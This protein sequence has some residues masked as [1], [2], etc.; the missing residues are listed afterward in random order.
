V[1][2]H[3]H[4]TTVR[5]YP[6]SVA[7]EG[8]PMIGAGADEP[9]AEERRAAER[10][11]LLG[12]FGVRAECLALGVDRLD[13]T[14]GIIERL[15]GLEEFFDEHPGYRER[16]TMVQ[17]AAPSRTRIPSY[18]ELRARVDETV[19]RI[20]WR[21]QTAH[22]KPIVL[23][24]RQ[25]SHNEVKRWYQTAD[26]CL[27]T[28]LH[29]GMNLVAKEYV[30]ARDDEDGVLVLSKFTGAAVELLDALIVNPYDIRGVSA[31]MY[32]GL[33][34]SRAERRQ[35]MQRMRRQVMEHN[36][37]LWAASVL[38][39]LRELR[40]EDTDGIEVSRTEPVAGPVTEIAGRKTA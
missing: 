31:A 33:E 35:R 6:I 8:V 2:R 27:V 16:L 40:L 26:M 3:G 7:F 25:C 37:Y 39:D 4:L 17:I 32:A 14:K 38:G 11:Q 36:I 1:R 22:W 30:A 15:V 34:M 23:I 9:D 10:R 29:D 5:P 20:N 13:Y 24:E 18:A 12:E 19:E 21:F 28:S